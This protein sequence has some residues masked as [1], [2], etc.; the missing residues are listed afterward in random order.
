VTV[1]RV[2]AEPTAVIAEATVTS[3]PALTASATAVP[4]PSATPS[5]T[6]FLTNTPTKRPLPT[7]TLV[8]AFPTKTV[9]MAIGTEGGDGASFHG[10]LSAPEIVV[11]TDG[12]VVWKEGDFDSGFFL[13]E[14][15]ISA[16]EMCNLLAQF[17]DSGFFQET[18]TIYAFDETTQYSEGASNYTIQINGPPMGYQQ[19]YQPYVPYLIESVATGFNLLLNYRP[20]DARPYNPSH[21]VVLIYPM[22]TDAP[23]AEPEPWPAELPPLIQLWP[24]P[25][26]Y[27]VYIEGELV[28]TITDVFGQNQLY[29]DHWYWVEDTL[30]YLIVRPLLPHETPDDFYPA[31]QSPVPIELPFT[32]DDPALLAATPEQ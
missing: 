27:R 20:A 3:T 7:V 11:Y 28:A 14:S 6:P 25:S 31:F 32:C 9:L 8:V 24:D 21:L 15:T 12:Q 22:T 26:N 1:T 16:A 10:Y 29:N 5:L 4:V 18:E 2:M 13:M 23:W 30:Y 19:I 17:R